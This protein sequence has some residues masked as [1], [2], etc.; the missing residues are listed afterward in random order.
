MKSF[1]V[2]S[3]LFLLSI[4]FASAQET[5][6][7]EVD[8]LKF[9]KMKSGKIYQLRE[10]DKDMYLTFQKIE[11][12]SFY[13]KERSFHYNEITELRNPKRKAV[14]DALLFPV[15]IGSCIAMSA[16]PINYFVGYFGGGDGGTDVMMRAVIFMGVETI[17]FYVARN[18][19]ATNKR[20][21][22]LSEKKKLNY[23]KVK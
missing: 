6:W 10:D 8:S 20:W 16:F 14:L 13:F 3:A 1:I 17:I 11:N 4:N 18:Y 5:Y 12:D 7:V 23:G 9:M 2:I 19:L 21:I 15:T 22:N